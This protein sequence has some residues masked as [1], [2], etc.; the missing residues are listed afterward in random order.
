LQAAAVQHGSIL[1]ALYKL[2]AAQQLSSEEIFWKNRQLQAAL[3]HG[4]I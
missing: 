1:S 2:P 4:D 3:Q